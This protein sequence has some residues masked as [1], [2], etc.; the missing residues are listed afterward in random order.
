MAV[1]DIRTNQ[2]ALHVWNTVF[3][4]HHFNGA[5]SHVASKPAIRKPFNQFLEKFCI[6]KFTN[7]FIQGIKVFQ[8]GAEKVGGLERL[9]VTISQ[10][11]AKTLQ[12]LPIEPFQWLALPQNSLA[13]KRKKSAT[14]LKWLFL[15]DSYYRNGLRKKIVEFV[16]MYL[17]TCNSNQGNNCFWFYHCL[18]R[19]NINSQ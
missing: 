17:T 14:L 18:Q 19:A 2:Y 1:T 13:I 12:K 9:F 3:G 6:A 5:Q 7:A 4:V 16:P 8:G 15:W 11:Y 10:P